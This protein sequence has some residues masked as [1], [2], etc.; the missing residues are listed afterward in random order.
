MQAVVIGATVFTGLIQL[1]PV[2]S[3]EA[4]TMQALTGMVLNTTSHISDYRAQKAK[5]EADLMRVRD[6]AS[7][8]TYASV[9]G[10][11]T[12]VAA[13]A[14]TKDATAAASLAGAVHTGVADTGRSVSEANA[15]LHEYNARFGDFYV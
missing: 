15:V 5:A 6:A 8:A 14:L 13:L 9:A 11:L 1:M 12:G 3:N 2:S 4:E 10:G 7:T